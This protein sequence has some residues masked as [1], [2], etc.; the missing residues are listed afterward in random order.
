MEKHGPRV[1]EANLD[2]ASEES[3]KTRGH[4]GSLG[5]R[6]EPRARKRALHTE[7]LACC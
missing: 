1:R 6:S 3:E 2:Y 7:T 4:E 5:R